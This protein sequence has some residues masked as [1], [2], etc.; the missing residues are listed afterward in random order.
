M[1]H[2]LMVDPNDPELERIRTIALALPE[3]DERVS[4]G[5][6]NFFTTKT[7]C[8]F[9][10]SQRIEGEWVQ[11][12]H[13]LMIKP[14]PDDEPALRADPRFWV[15]AYLG[16]SGWLGVDLVDLDEGETEE[17]IDAS[18]RATAPKRLIRLLNEA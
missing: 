4:H 14:D 1:A 3:A 11:H 17:L 15:P 9:G 6:P 5:R 10:G 8:Y 12:S 13:A 16:P 7:F 18:Y 2:P